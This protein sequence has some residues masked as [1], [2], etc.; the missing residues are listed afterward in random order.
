M[1]LPNRLSMLRILMVPIFVACY[2]VDHIAMPFVAVGIFVLAAF[3]DFLD[4]YIA[5]KYHLVSDLG[6]LL[7]PIADKLLVTAALFV[8]V[9]TNP[10]GTQWGM[11]VL[12]GSS[13]LIVGREL[14]ISAVRQIAASKGIV[15]QANLWGKI[16]TVTQ[17]IAIPMLIVLNARQ[18]FPQ[19]VQFF[20]IFQWIALA[21]FGLA[22]VM[23]V[24]S[25]TIYI[26]DNKKVFAE[27][28]ND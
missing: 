17:M 2:F 26:V 16:K 28:K 14:L 4:G 10:I 24:V 20:D 22:T 19:A 6:K 12:A 25:G 5:R 15:L 8:L 7:D 1:N 3:T 9:A 13:A 18:Y 21:L 11:I 27:V 23:T